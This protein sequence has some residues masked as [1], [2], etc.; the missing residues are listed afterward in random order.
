MYRITIWDS[1]KYKVKREW[2]EGQ[3]IGSMLVRE[4]LV[5]VGT[6]DNIV[7]YDAKTTKPKIVLNGH[8]KT[9]NTIAK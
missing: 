8:S 1:N 2:V 5:W 7:I 4:G 3:T 9:V 6:E